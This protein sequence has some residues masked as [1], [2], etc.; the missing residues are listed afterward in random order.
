MPGLADDVLF[1]AA[2]DVDA[3]GASYS[4]T[5]TERSEMDAI[6]LVQ[7]SLCLVKVRGVVSSAIST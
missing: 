3:R 5:H 1:Q 4:T 6:H 7:C 2:A